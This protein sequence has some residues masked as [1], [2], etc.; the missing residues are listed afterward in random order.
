MTCRSLWPTYGAAAFHATVSIKQHLQNMDCSVVETAWQGLK[1]IEVFGHHLSQ[2]VLAVQV[3]MEQLHG[4]SAPP[5]PP[6][7]SR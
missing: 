4:R 5:S 6:P 1:S 7:C 2:W 3:Q